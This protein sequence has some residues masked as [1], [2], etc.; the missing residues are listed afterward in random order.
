VG[1]NTQTSTRAPTDARDRRSRGWSIR[2]RTDFRAVYGVSVV[3]LGV[4]DPARA[5]AGLPVFVRTAT[6]VAAESLPSIWT[7]R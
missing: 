1:I 2:R 5:S 6:A 4:R 3:H 7:T